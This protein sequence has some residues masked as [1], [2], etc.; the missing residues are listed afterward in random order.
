[1]GR[2]SKQTSS[3][4]PSASASGTHSSRSLPRETSAT[5]DP[6]YGAA[7]VAKGCRQSVGCYLASMYPAHELIPHQTIVAGNR[8]INDLP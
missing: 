3:N 1:M 4:G 5:G 2:A 6:I 8:G 7:G